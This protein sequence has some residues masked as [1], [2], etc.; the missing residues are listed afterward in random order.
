[1]EKIGNENISEKDEKVIF[2]I[3]K[4]LARFLILFLDGILR[5]LRREKDQQGT[6]ECL[7]KLLIFQKN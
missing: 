7:G 1:M 4:E 3:S 5:W 2:P 6:E